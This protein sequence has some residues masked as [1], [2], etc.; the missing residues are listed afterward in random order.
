MAL[1]LCY[2]ELTN[3]YTNGGLSFMQTLDISF[4]QQYIQLDTLLG[5]LFGSDRGVSDYLEAMEDDDP[6]AQRL[7]IPDWL[8]DYQA[9]HRLRHLRNKITH[10]PSEDGFC[11]QADLAL[12]QQVYQRCIIRDDPLTRLRLAQEAAEQMPTPRRESRVG[13]TIFL[14]LCAAAILATVYFNLIK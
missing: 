2:N 5:Q 3:P 12:L 7:E 14:I 10:E 1:Y 13:S 9:L 11:S 8:E 6:T 4:L